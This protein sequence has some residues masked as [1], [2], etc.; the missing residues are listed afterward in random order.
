MCDDLVSL[1]AVSTLV[2]ISLLNPLCVCRHIRQSVIFQLTGL[3]YL[4]I[5]KT[6]CFDVYMFGMSFYITSGVKKSNINFSVVF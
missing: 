6:A 3:D 4:G 2:L 1:D 5:F